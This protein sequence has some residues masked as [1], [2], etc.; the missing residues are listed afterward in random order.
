MFVATAGGTGTVTVNGGTLLAAA[1]PIILGSNGQG[2]LAVSGGGRIVADGL[3]IGGGS[4][5]SGTA[6]V[7]N[8]TVSVAGLDHPFFVG[9]TNA[10]GFLS[11]GSGGTVTTGTFLDINATGAGQ[12]DVRVAGGTFVSTSSFYSGLIVG[13]TGSGS[14]DVSDLGI[15][16]RVPARSPSA[17]R[18]AATAQ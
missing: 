1:A 5:G 3:T 12:A 9:Y 8:G 7:V 16:N 4:G 13:D 17:T 11:I 18:R 6:T 10:S 2:S 14:L 15:V